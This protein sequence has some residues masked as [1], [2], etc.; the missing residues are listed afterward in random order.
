MNGCMDGKTNRRKNK[1]SIVFIVGNP[2]EVSAHV[3]LHCFVRSATS[4]EM[5]TNKLSSERLK[6]R[7]GK[8]T[9]RN[10]MKNDVKSGRRKNWREMKKKKKS[11]YKRKRRE[12]K[13]EN[14]EDDD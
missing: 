9:E 10:A 12:E 8:K 13:K 14:V 3:L 7:R 6:K 2:D 5:E 1:S 11:D 4:K